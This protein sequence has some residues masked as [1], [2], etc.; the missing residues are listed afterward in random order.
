MK[1][2]NWIPR[3]MFY[4]VMWPSMISGL[5]L[6]A[7]DI[8]DALV[9]GSQLGEKGLAAIG[10]VTPVYMLYNLFGYGFATGGCVNHGKLA[11]Q[12]R[13]KTA[14]CHFRTDAGPSCWHCARSTPARC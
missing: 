3:S 1:K 10:L 6:A 2:A 5:A 4:R 13:E 14:L 7:A 9:V 8:A 11:A 12:G